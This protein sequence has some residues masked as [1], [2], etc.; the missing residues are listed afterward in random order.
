MKI[1]EILREI[2]FFRE[3]N[4]LIGN[5]QLFSRNELVSRKIVKLFLAKYREI[6]KCSSQ[7]N[8]TNFYLRDFS[9]RCLKFLENGGTH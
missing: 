3:T 9:G 7:I 6:G 8:L 2:Q 1:E 5:L 4:V